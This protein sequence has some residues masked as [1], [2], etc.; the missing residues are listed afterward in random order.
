MNILNF[1]RKKKAN[2]VQSTIDAFQFNWTMSYRID[3]EVSD[4]SYGCTYTKQK[5]QDDDEET[6]KSWIANEFKNRNTS[7]LWF[8][9]NC[10]PKLRLQFASSLSSYF[11]LK[12]YGSCASQI[13]GFF[14]SLFSSS[15]GR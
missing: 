1:F 6:F 12:V 9:S 10:A 15:C 3:A 14:S 2:P 7:A 13:S 5:E 4:C 11:R 8:V